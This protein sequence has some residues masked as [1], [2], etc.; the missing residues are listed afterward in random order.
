MIL[1]PH[2]C[3][4]SQPAVTPSN[5]ETGGKALLKKNWRI[6]YY[7]RDPEF[8]DDYPYGKPIPVKGMNRYKTLEE[9]REATQILIDEILYM[10]KVEGYNPITKKKNGPEIELDFDIHPETTVCEA[11]EKARKKINGEDS[12]LSDL[13]TATK[14]FNISC[15]QLRY[16]PLRIGDLKRKHVYNILENQSNQNAYTNERYNKIRAYMHMV[17]KQLVKSD[18][19]E[20]NIIS[21]IEKKKETK[22]IKI[23]FTDDEIKI[24]SIYLKENH[25][26]FYRYIQIFFH[27]GSRSTELF[28]LKRKDIDM[29]NQRF[30]VMV[31]KTKTNEEQWR[32][33][34]KNALKY[35]EQ[36]YNAA[37]LNDYIFSYN[38]CP[39]ETKIAARQ[40]SDKWRKYVKMRLG[41]KKNFYKL[42]HLHTTK[43]I[44]LYDDRK[45]AAGLNGHKSTDMNDKHYD[46][47]HEHRIIEK[48]K[49]IDVT[50]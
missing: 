18:A 29:D 45:F 24:I 33:I 44:S 43:V 5:W 27:S 21:N 50:L 41:I 31:K 17:F 9:R 11:V 48:A 40:V 14:Y 38:F 19:I 15:R 34:N 3:S 26:G 16:H 35:W 8:K 32:G 39:G 1:L 22:K 6:H 25:F 37:G 12:T 30:K 46:T 47:L 23:G 2:G 10:L 42:K 7:F 28:R 13:K 36:L 20:H 49:K 4:C